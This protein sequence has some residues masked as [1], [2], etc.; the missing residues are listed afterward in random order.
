M[1]K[2]AKIFG[3]ASGLKTETN[4]KVLKISNIRGGGN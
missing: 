4:A 3:A 2:Y 1:K